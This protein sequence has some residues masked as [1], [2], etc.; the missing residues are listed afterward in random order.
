M[1][2]SQSYIVNELYTNNNSVYYCM[3]AKMS[4]ATIA[5]AV[6]SVHFLWLQCWWC[7]NSISSPCGLQCCCNCICYFLQCIHAEYLIITWNL[8]SLEN[9]NIFL[10]ISVCHGNT[11]CKIS[12]LIM[13]I[14]RITLVTMHILL[15]HIGRRYDWHVSNVAKGCI[16]LREYFTY[17]YSLMTTQIIYA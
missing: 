13:L 7:P 6:V 3:T 4:C 9:K 10:H 2:H 16:Q 11:Y 1:L 15:P 5:K 17:S 8:W 12:E 14:E